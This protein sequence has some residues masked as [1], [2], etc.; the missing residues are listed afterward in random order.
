MRFGREEGAELASKHIPGLFLYEQ[1]HQ[2]VLQQVSTCLLVKL[3]TFHRKRRDE[4]WKDMDWDARCSGQCNSVDGS[5]WTALVWKMPWEMD[6]RPLVVC[7]GGK[8]VF[9]Y[10]RTALCSLV[11]LIN[12]PK[13]SEA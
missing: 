7:I 10:K 8:V 11:E 6:T 1:Q 13:Q 4:P 12:D 3:F 9:A 5:A 2:G